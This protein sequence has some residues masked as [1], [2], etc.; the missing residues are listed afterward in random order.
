VNSRVAVGI[1]A[2]LLSATASGALAQT[3][4]A[5]AAA[6]APN[7][8]PNLVLATLLTDYEAFL[9]ANDPIS[10][11]LEGDQAAR[12][13][14]PDAT[15]AA[16]LATQAPLESFL[17][18]AQA[19][20]QTG[21]ASEDRLNRD[22][23]IWVL[24]RAIEAIRYDSGRLAFNSEGGVGQNIAYV[25]GVTRITSRADADA[26]IARLE[27]LP[28]LYDDSLENARR[29]LATGFTQPKSVTESYLV[30][31][32]NEVAFT[33][34]TDPLLKP[35]A[36]LPA[37]IPA[38][39]QRAL[40]ARAAA[41]VAEQINPRRRQWL[42]FVQ[43]DYLPAA[44]D[45]VGIGSRPGG[46]DYYAFQARSTCRPS[47]RCCARIRVLRDQPP[48]VAGEVQRDRQA[49]R[50]P[51]ARPLRRPAAPDLRRAARAGQH[52][53]GLHHRPL[54]RRRSQG[55]PGRRADDQ[56]LRAGPAAAL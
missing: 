24:R 9:K 19:I 45:A 28:K 39:D 11:G 49:R 15:R 50:R 17:A 26:W 35:F 46:K 44:L 6:A 22:F 52:R 30:S 10:A 41:I 25:A 18:R 53:A 13:K 37:S 5:P 21:L 3:A 34:D 47:S 8:A 12:S 4:P 48:A 1:A 54:F 38:A 23:L 42:A 55:R 36:A 16:E 2:L 14:L 7:P 56:H 51:T 27:A 32:R 20:P 40:Q 29:G 33:P 31:L 43:D